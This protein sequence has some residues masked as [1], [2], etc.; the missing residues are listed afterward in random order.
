MGEGA[1]LPE[2]LRLV[3]E[4]FGGAFS[5]DL[6]TGLP[7]QDRGVLR[8]DLEKLLVFTPGHVSLYALTPAAGTP[9]G[10]DPRYTALLPP[11][12]EADR[13]WLMGR[14]FLEQAGY[15]QYEVSN[16]ALPGRESAH[17]IRYWRME[18]WLGLG[19]AAS[20]TIIDDHSGRGIRYTIGADT[21]AYLNASVAD[22]TPTPPGSPLVFTED[23]DPLTLMRETCLMGFRYLAGPDPLLF[24]RRFRRD[25]GECIPGTL[26][27]WRGRGLLRPDKIAL[28]REGLLF[29]NPFLAECFEEL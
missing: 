13:L 11:A 27:R 23:L 28:T 1:L 9:L 25:I 21:E 26:A 6:I 22:R 7:G 15:A 3:R 29:L 19:A 24:A 14:D 2:R 4:Y 17:N 5:V 20:G 12:D 18:N 10:E 8:E 16:F